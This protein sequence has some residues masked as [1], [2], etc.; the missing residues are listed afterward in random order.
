LVIGPSLRSVV[1]V[2]YRLDPVVRTRHLEHYQL[3]QLLRLVDHTDD[4]ELPVCVEHRDKPDFVVSTRTRTIGLETTSFTDEEVMRASDLHDRH[5]RKAFIVT[6]GLRDGARRRSNAEITQTMLSLEAPW[7]DVIETAEHVA[8][9]ICERIRLKCQ[10]FQSSAFAKFRENWLLLTDYRNPLSNSISD[11]VIARQL[12]E[13]V[14]RGDVFG[15]EFDRIYICYGPR[16]FRLQRGA[17][18]TKL[19]PHKN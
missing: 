19:V 10:K 11:N 1:D 2:L 4:L 3:Q 13:A 5:Y 15:T 16:C 18:A 8:E 17:V 12:L 14:Q 6:S 7:A 9:K